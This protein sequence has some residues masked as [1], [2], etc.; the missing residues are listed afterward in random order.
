MMLNQ[1]R[2]G[3]SHELHMVEDDGGF[4]AKISHQPAFG[5]RCE[6]AAPEQ[7]QR[8]RV[9]FEQSPAT[10]AIECPDRGDP[11]RHAIELPAKVI[12][13]LRWNEFHGIECGAGH[14]EEADLQP[15]RQPVQGTAAFSNLGELVRVESE[16]ML[17][18]ER[19][20]RCG[21]SLLTEISVLP[22]THR[23]GLRRADHGVWNDCAPMMGLGAGGMAAVDIAIPGDAQTIVC[24]SPG[25]AISTAAIPPAPSPIMGAQSFQT[26]W[27]ARR[28]PRRCVDGS[29]DISVR[30]DS[31]RRC[32]RSRS[33]ISSLS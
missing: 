10:P 16:E 15:E 21:E 5:M 4:L 7:S 23:R 20:Q 24:A 22:S 30:S 29:T 6:L 8:R 27:S 11:R 1:P 13:D 33:S 28:R 31:P 26:P 14:L 12:E 9:M 25:M 3:A 19:R 18:L 17:D 2:A 32:R